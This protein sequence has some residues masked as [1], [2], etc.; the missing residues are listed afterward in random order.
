LTAAEAIPASRV[1]IF[2]RSGH[3]AHT[4][5]PALFAEFVATTSPMQLDEDK[6]R[7]VL[8]AGPAVK[9]RRANWGR[10]TG[11]TQG[12]T[13]TGSPWALPSK[14]RCG[15]LER[16]AR[17]SGSGVRTEW[18]FVGVGDGPSSHPRQTGK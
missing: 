16:R 12:A 11:C 7:A 18:H 10:S 14:R 13:S 5:E 3:F 2:D 15:Q 8:T 9:S 1:M 17:R 6:W 4:Y